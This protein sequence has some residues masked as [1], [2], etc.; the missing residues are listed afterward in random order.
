MNPKEKRITFFHNG[1][2][3]TIQCKIEENLFERFSN[4][5]NKDLENMVFLYNGNIMKED[6]DLKKIKENQIKIL[7][8]DFEFEREQNESLKQ[9]KEIIC[10]IC[11]ELCEININKYKIS[12]KNCINKHCF[13]N[14]IINGFN[15][16]QKINEKEILCKKCGN[17]KLEAYDNKFFICCN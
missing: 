13:P 1:E 4:K 15:D 8:I 6:F 11:N 16:F 9:S 7:I 5:I 14:L 3:I 2:T 17:N 12:L 10:P